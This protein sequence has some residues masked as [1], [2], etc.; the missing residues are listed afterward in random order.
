MRQWVDAG[1]WPGVTM[2]Q[3]HAQMP[4]VKKP[5]IKADPNIQDIPDWLARWELARVLSYVKRYDES[6]GEYRKLIKEK[7]GLHEVR[8]EMATVLYWQGKKEAAI[9]ELEEM[10]L[11]AIDNQTRILMADL[12]KIQKQYAKSE[13]IYRAYLDKAPKDDTVRLKL[14]EMLSWEK[15]YN[16][17]LMEYEKVLKDRP[18]DRQ[19]RR[20]YAFVLIWAG[21]QT[22]AIRELKATLK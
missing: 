16:D 14:A 6:I 12:Y 20:K 3:S 18:D 11:Q 10:P 21:R 2:S 7:P 4:A 19:V 9:K 22:D 5:E 8:A 13:K 15:R 17:S 1:R